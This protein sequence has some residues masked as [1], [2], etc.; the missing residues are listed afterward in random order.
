MH[1]IVIDEDGGISGTPKAILEKWTGLSKIS[2]ARTAEGS[3]NYYADALYSGSS[4]IYWM[5][6]PGVL[7]VMVIQLLHRVLHYILLHLKLSLQYH[8]LV[9]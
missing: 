4:Y 3:A 9:V 2:D 1:I 8:L 7:L 6:H 5:D